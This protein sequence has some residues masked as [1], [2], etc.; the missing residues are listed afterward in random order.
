[1]MRKLHS[2]LGLLIALLAIVIA[3]S[4]AILSLDPALERLGSTIPADGQINVATLA[5]RVAQHYPGVEQIQRTPAGSIIVYYNRDGQTGVERVDP[6]S[7]QGIG[8]YAVSPFS[9]WMKNLHRSWLLDTPGRVVSGLIALVMLVLSISGAMLL[10][11]RV[12]GWRHLADP[13]R[14]NLIQRWHTQTGRFVVLGLLLSVL[15]GVY[16]SAATFAL[17]PDGM[18]AE[19]NFPST[20]VGGPVAPITTLP[21]LAA[22]DLNS[23]RE[24]V[25]PSPGDAS[26]VYSLATDQG[27]GYVDQSSGE[28]LSYQPYGGFRQTYE[29]IYQLHTGEGLWWLALLLGLC[30]LSVPLLSATGTLTWWQRRQSMPRIVGNSAAN[31]AD[32]VILVGSENN[33]TW[34]FANTLHDALR[35]TG[36]RVHTAAMNQL[37]TEYPKAERLFILTATYGDGDAPSSAQQFLTRLSKTRIHST[38]GFAVL[39]FGDR[40][41]PQFCKFAYDVEVALLTQGWQRLLDIDT[42]DRQSAQAFTHW[43]NA[44]GQLIGKELNLVHI[45]KR[46][47]TDAFALIERADY[48]EKVQAPT[49]ILRFAAVPSHGLKDHIIRLFGGNGL[50]YFEAGDLLGVVPPGSTIPRFYSLASKTS[51]G[52]LEICVRKLQGGLCSEFLHGLQP[53]GRMDAFIQLH[54]DFR[55]A[56]GKAPVILIGSGTG[57]GPLAGFIRNNTGKHP[58]YLYWG[59]RDPASDFLYKPELDAYLADGRLTGLHAAFSRVQDGAY[60]Q[61]RVLGDAIQ[62]RLLLENEGQVL[63]CG[64]R[65]MAKNIAHALDEVLAPL[66]LSVAI[67]KAQ[68]RYREDVF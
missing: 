28:L 41:F 11:K 68:G 39:G 40:Q 14:G 25:Y 51:D 65:A 53:G 22:A 50:P 7:G 60:V 12:G 43:G 20:V 23:L 32:T 13:L 56:A 44:V 48:G 16:M 64:S 54:P 66:N 34:G 45:P 63:V 67:L 17:V 10:I 33:S 59:G 2:L 29:L 24:L 38:I 30:A 46:P 8:T 49:S 27:E 42:I 57:I 6:Q 37:A 5:G 1:M 21:A 58:M 47:P 18:D 26:G 35:K 61:D 62:L 19:P 3:I 52:F 36:L 31:S 55:P 4:G 9:R 15:T